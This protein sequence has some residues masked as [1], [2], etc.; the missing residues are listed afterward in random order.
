MDRRWD[1]LSRRAFVVGTAGL[2]LLGGCGRLPGQAQPKVYRV[3]WLDNAGNDGWYEA[4]QQGMREAGYLEGQNLVLDVWHSPYDEEQSRARARELVQFAPNVIV[5][6]TSLNARAARKATDTI[7]IVFGVTSDPVREG[8]VA[9]FARPGGNATGL[10]VMNTA[11]SAKRV[12]LLAQ[13]VP[14]LGRLAIFSMDGNVTSLNIDETDAA[15]RRLGIEPWL[16]EAQSERD[17]AGLLETAAREGAGAILALP[18]TRSL[19]ARMAQLAI[20][21]RL[22]MMC[23]QREFVEAGGLMSY[24]PNYVANFRRVAVYVDKILKGANPADLPIEQPMTFDFVVNM[25]TAQALG[26]TFPNDIMLQ[27]TEVIQ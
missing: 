2:G 13:T 3:G 22:P 10:S 14:T 11:L 23:P 9:S 16:L 24:G 8:L 4:F 19:A 12:E 17:L 20:Q 6:T 15:A 18:G 1:R 7:P 21:H 25:K 26:I 5:A 27:V